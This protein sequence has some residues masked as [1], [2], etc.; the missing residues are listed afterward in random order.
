MIIRCSLC[1]RKYS[2]RKTLSVC[3]A[4]IEDTT[5]RNPWQKKIPPK[6]CQGTLSPASL[7]VFDLASGKYYGKDGSV[8]VLAEFAGVYDDDELDALLLAKYGTTDRDLL[9]RKC[10]IL[11]V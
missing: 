3:L 5:P 1:A 9:A 2:T 10:T 7:S 6:Y 4:E 11:R 8:T